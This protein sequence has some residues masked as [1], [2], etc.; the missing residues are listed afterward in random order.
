MGSLDDLEN[1]RGIGDFE[2]TGHISHF[3]GIV[4]IEFVRSKSYE[5][6][7]FANRDFVVEDD[8]IFLGI[9]IPHSLLHDDFD[10]GL[11]V[12]HSERSPHLV[13]HQ[14]QKNYLASVESF[15]QPGQTNLSLEI[16]QRG[17]PERRGRRTLAFSLCFLASGSAL[18]PLLPTPMKFHQKYCVLRG[19]ASVLEYRLTTPTDYTWRSPNRNSPGEC[20]TEAQSRPTSSH[21]K[22]CKEASIADASSRQ[23]SSMFVVAASISNRSSPTRFFRSETLRSPCDS[24]EAKVKILCRSVVEDELAAQRDSPVSEAAAT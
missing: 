10:S 13:A 5:G 14:I 17:V 18:H 23:T 6:R 12:D 11:E 22:F 19:M 24:S 21:R 8:D 2:C 3:E 9:C 16:G 15:V 7:H 1:M 20:P 4:S